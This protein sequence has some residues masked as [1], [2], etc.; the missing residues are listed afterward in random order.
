MAAVAEDEQD[1]GGSGGDEQDGGGS[2]G[3]EQ[4]GGG[5]GVDIVTPIAPMD[6]G[7]RRDMGTPI[8]PMDDG[9]RRDMGTPI[10]PMD[11]GDNDVSGSG[12]KAGSTVLMKCIEDQAYFN[13]GNITKNELDNCY[14]ATYGFGNSQNTPQPSSKGF[15]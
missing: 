14:Y 10:A 7:G 11:D 9:G 8:A 2:G 1:G 5:S 15:G 3:D 12:S 6:D 13:S 4:D